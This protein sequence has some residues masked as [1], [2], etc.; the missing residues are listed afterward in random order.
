MLHG[1]RVADGDGDV[2]GDYFGSLELQ[3]SPLRDKQNLDGDEA[4]DLSA[5]DGNFISPLEM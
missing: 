5:G 1:F 2:G 3:E 4:T